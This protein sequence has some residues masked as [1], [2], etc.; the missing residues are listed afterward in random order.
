M[1]STEIMAVRMLAKFPVSTATA[2]AASSVG[3]GATA[4]VLATMEAKAAT[5]KMS[6]RYE[7]MQ[8]SF[9]A[10]SSMFSAM[11]V[12]SVC[13]LWRMEANSAPKSCMAPKKMPPMSTHRSTGTQPKMA[14]WM[15]PLMGPA[16][17]M[18]EKWWPSTT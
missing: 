17:A 5:T 8:N 3:T 12:A 18:D 4:K 16:P 1:N 6:V 13:P 2:L 15:G 11:T 14:A 10:V 7:K 9:L